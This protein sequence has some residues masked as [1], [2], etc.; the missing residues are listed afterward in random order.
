VELQHLERIFSVRFRLPWT[1]PLIELDITQDFIKS[2]IPRCGN[3]AAVMEIDEH[4]KCLGCKDFCVSS[5]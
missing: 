5:G 3:Q 4:L 1:Y 2:K